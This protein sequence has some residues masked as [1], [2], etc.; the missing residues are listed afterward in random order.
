MNEMKK[1][2]FS[3]RVFPADITP[4]EATAIAPSNVLSSLEKRQ[5][6]SGVVKR[7]GSVATPHFDE[8][9]TREDFRVVKRHILS[10]ID[11]ERSEK[12]KDPRTILVT[13][14]SPQEGNRQFVPHVL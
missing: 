10:R 4:V 11:A 13:C 6:R 3:G 5:D 7:V 2:P 1:V 8:S 12:D 9:R 14:A